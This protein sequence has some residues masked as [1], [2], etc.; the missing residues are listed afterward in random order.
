MCVQVPKEA[1]RGHQVPCELELQVVVSHQAWFPEIKLCKRG[2]GS[3]PLSRLC[4]WHC[5][6]KTPPPPLSRLYT[7]PL[8]SFGSHRDQG[9]PHFLQTSPSLSPS[10]AMG[11]VASLGSHVTRQKTEATSFLVSH[12][13]PSAACYPPMSFSSVLH[14]DLV[15]QIHHIRS[16]FC[17]FLSRVK[18][19]GGWSGRQTQEM[20]FLLNF[21]L[22]LCV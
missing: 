1:R 10:V 19:R 12:D 11:E 20:N 6:F 15:G 9:T 4:S 2:P 13:Q 5:A 7:L 14:L 21:C 16:E 17:F 22:F 3:S 8:V 18:A